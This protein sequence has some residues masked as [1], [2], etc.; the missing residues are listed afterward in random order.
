MGNCPELSGLRSPAEKTEFIKGEEECAVKPE[1]RLSAYR[2][3]KGR[4]PERTVLQKGRV[5]SQTNGPQ[6]SSLPWPCACV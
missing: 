6:W 1:S 3:P 4:N 2:L 5:T